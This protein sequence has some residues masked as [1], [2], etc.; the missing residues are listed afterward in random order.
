MPN[1][2]ELFDTISSRYDRFNHLTS[3]GIDRCWRRRAIRAMV[4]A[5]NV[6]DVAIGTADLTIEMLRQG[7]AQQIEGLDLSE[8]MMQIG[9]KKVEQQGLQDK[10]HFTLGSAQTMPYK[11]ATFDAL[12][13]AYGIRNFSDLEAGLREF[14]RVLKPGGQLLILEFSYPQKRLMAALYT[15][16]FRY[17][18][19]W[20]GALLTHDK[21]AFQYFY[22]SVRNFI[23]GE[24]LCE[25]L[26]QF[27]FWPIRHQPMTFGIST[28][29]LATK[30][31]QPS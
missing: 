21:S 25:K 29:Y 16:Y 17:I 20:I 28:L 6:L 27:G 11:D 24:K 9:A 15:F 31:T 19:T 5:K 22:H 4:P 7:K 3:F 18:I 30:P 2:G 8:Q 14:Y 23:W 10:V 1:I 12:T 26:Q 13:C